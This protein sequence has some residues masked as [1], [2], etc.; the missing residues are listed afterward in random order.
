MSLSYLI[1]LYG[2]S[3]M[4]NPLLC[5]WIIS[6]FLRFKSSGSPSILTSVWKKKKSLPTILYLIFQDINKSTYK[7]LYVCKF[8]VRSYNHTQYLFFISYN[9]LTGKLQQTKQNKTN[10]LSHLVKSQATATMWTPLLFSCWP[11]L[12]NVNYISSQ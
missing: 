2:L 3:H 7:T 11:F 4:K 6:D 5:S 10:N 9:L 12:E 1:G 8:N